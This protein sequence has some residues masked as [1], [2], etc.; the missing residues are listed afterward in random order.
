LYKFETL[1]NLPLAE[2][3]KIPKFHNKGSY[4]FGKKYD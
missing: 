4:K 2:K 1:K 3:H